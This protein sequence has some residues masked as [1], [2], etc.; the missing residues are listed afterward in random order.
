MANLVPKVNNTG[1]IGTDAKKWSNVHTTNL[2]LGAQSSPLSLNSQRITDLS[3]P[4]ALT[5]AAT[6][7]Y[8]DNAI[9]G[10]SA[11]DSVRASTTEAG[12]LATSFE[13]GQA[14][15]GVTLSTG[16]RILIKDQASGEE[17]GIYTVNA[18]GAPTRAGDFDSAEQIEKGAYIFVE[19]GTVNANS[20][21]VLTTD[22]SITVDTTAL[23]FTQFSGAGQITAGS[24]ITKSGNSISVDPQQMN[25]TNNEFSVA[26]STNLLTQVG[27]QDFVSKISM[28][29]FANFLVDS[30][31]TNGLSSSSGR[32][33]IDISS[34]AA[35]NT[36]SDADIILIED[37]DDSSALKKVTKSNFASSLG[38]TINDLSD[39]T[40]TSAASGEYLRYD[41]SAWI[42]ESLSISDDTSP[43]L[44]GSLD[45]NGQDIVSLSNGNITLTPDGTGVVR[46]DGSNGID[47]QSG[48]VSVKNS[49]AV[50]NIKLYCEVGNA[51]YTQVQSAAHADYSG[52]VTLTLPTSSGTLV[53]SGDTGTVT[54]AM[55]A[56]S[57]EASKMNNS[58]FADLETLGAPTT[59]GEFIVATGAGAFAYESGVTV[60]TSLGLGTGDSPEFTS[61]TLSGQAA[62]LAMNSQQ[63]TGL[64]APTSD[65][66]AATKA[67]VDGV[68]QGLDVKDSVVAATTASF[69][70]TQAGTVDT[71]ILNDGDGGFST[72]NSSL[73]IDGV[74]LSQGD[75]VLIKDGVD[76]NNTG[77][78]QAK[79]GIYTVGP[80]GGALALLTRSSDMDSNSGVTAGS[81]CFVEQGTNNADVGFVITT[82]GSITIGTTS[83]TFSQFSGAGSVTAGAA[84]TKTGNTLDVAVDSSGGLEINN[85]ELRVKAAGITSAMLA[86][87]IANSKLNTL[88]T[89][90]KVALSSLDL[91]GG[92]DIGADLVDADLIIVDDGAGGTNRSSALSRIK[93]YIFSSVSGDASA[94]DT[95]A[96][97]VGS[98]SVA[99]TDITAGSGAATL[100][101]SGDININSTSNGADIYLNVKNDGG[102]NVQG[103]KVHGQDATHGYG[104]VE[105]QGTLGVRKIIPDFSS[106]F[107]S[108]GTATNPWGDLF[109]ADNK[110][111][112]F[113]NDQE[114]SLQH[115]PDDGLI[116]RMTGAATYDPKFVL[117]SDSDATIGPMLQLRQD[118]TTPAD[119][120]RVG[121]IEF[122]GDDSVG[123]VTSF[124]QIMGISK[125]VTS[126]AEVGKVVI[127]AYP[128]LSSTLGLSVE[129]VSGSTTKVKVNIDTHNGSDSGLHLDG[130]L[131]TATADELNLLDGATSA[132][133][134][135][136]VDADRVIVNDAGIMKQVALSDVKTYVNAGSSSADFSNVG[137]NIL[138][139][140][141][142]TYSLGSA[143][144]EWSDLYMGDGSRIYLGNDQDVY[145]EHDPDAGVIL[146]LAT[147]AALT[148]TFTLKTAW[149][150]NAASGG[151]IEFLSE[152]SSPASNDIIGTIKVTSKNSAAGNHDYSSIR[153]KI[154]SPTNNLEA[155][156][157]YFYASTGGF[158][159]GN[160]ATESLKILGDASGN[161]IVDVSLHDGASSGL[162]LGGTLVTATA[163]ELNILDGVTAT[164]TELNLLDGATSAQATTLVDADRVIVNDAGTM[165]QVALSDVKTYIN[166]GG[167]SADF[168][169]VGE[170]ILPS[171]ANTYSLGSAAAE[172]S[173]LYM[174][175]GSRIYLGNDQD[176]YFEHDPDDGVQLHMASE[177]SIEPTFKIVHNNASSNFQ[178][179]SLQLVNQTLD[180]S[181]DIIGSLRYVDGSNT[182]AVI[183]G[184]G[185]G[186][187]SGT[188]TKLYMSVCPSGGTAQSALSITGVSNTDGT[189]VQVHDHNGSTTGL[190]LGNT[191][192][193]ASG[194]ELNILDGVTATTAELNILDGVTATT[195]ELNLL[196]GATSAQATTLQN[197]DRVIVNDAGI[198]KQVALSDVKTYVG[199]GTFE[200]S[201]IELGDMLLNYSGSST[202]QYLRLTMAANSSNGEPIFLIENDTTSSSGGK[203][204]FSVKE[205][206]SNLVGDG[207]T[208]GTIEWRETE[209]NGGTSFW[210]YQRGKVLDHTNNYGSLEFQVRSGTT[211]PATAISIEGSAG[212]TLVD[213]EDHDGTDSGLKLGGALVTATAS[214]LNI[215]DGATVEASE[216]NVLDVSAQSPADSEV[217]TYTAANGLHWAAAGGGGASAPTVTSASPSSAYT[218]T[219]HSGIEEIYLLTPST[220]ITV[221]LPGAATAGSGYKYQ[222][223]NL[224]AN[225][226]TI[227]PNASETIDGSATFDLS[228]QYSSVTI[229]SDGS[230]W[231]II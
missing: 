198:M 131:V 179:P 184:A 63:I 137:E 89:A 75:R 126:G 213:I 142:N 83:I 80:L 2:S 122:T 57:I 71:I 108:L 78:S 225:T 121:T 229:V 17:N 35:K 128:S 209:S 48:E 113:G 15:D 24:G 34:L 150:T 195:A 90:N 201:A 170:N 192:V 196:D 140:V 44:G 164:T 5:D 72:A 82:D 42:D 95:G 97:T 127:G 86:G 111:I 69:T 16:D 212:G 203:L 167:G 145:F 98:S 159:A 101:T 138:P 45:V 199:S 33:S 161:S 230:N 160:A 228:S 88:T 43:Q 74:S 105:I 187:A 99:L 103:I 190:K 50:S 106:S 210:C 91:D 231:F 100:A 143:A 23:S 110:Y 200:A 136:L 226:I 158:P 148:P 8:V 114:I 30:N 61:L 178:G 163:T 222:V 204:S 92:T 3:D 59:D 172:W 149:G 11:K 153:S 219:T 18:S 70:T 216:L 154:E 173:D 10:L 202:S 73:T 118:S 133:A 139:S 191:L 37:S 197:T 132:Q 207:D 67:Y 183:Y 116:L 12:T 174:G 38:S 206:N 215:L 205:A 182:G 155:G 1:S 62:P 36:L 53:S 81:F 40:I 181:S 144:A 76:E 32:M 115:D 22:G 165:K 20:G 157:L 135:T 120:D 189:I 123:N 151:Q 109:L 52:N 13:N 7:S 176:V 19:E 221:N 56:G 64:A 152:T 49:G 77:V 87:S 134:T 21:F 175:D 9:Q 66:D 60:R 224:S 129:G 117:L 14:I 217:L 58:V 6:K 162:K 31:T 41:G 55:L 96:F 107:S 218:I 39:V 4:T 169:N 156:G 46:I 28:G 223:K 51:H 141:A 193:T 147:D 104:Y 93:K 68:A 227:D 171:A 26:S 102:G 188:G 168:S 65:T 94:T 119:N 47:M 29:D 79:N 220:A 185:Q 85:D 125:S 84:L 211:T 130:T 214:E 166:S 146:D 177:G 54:N 124:G 27:S 186:G 180:A 25:T 112:K 208:L 194:S